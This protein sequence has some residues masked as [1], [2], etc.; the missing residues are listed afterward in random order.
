MNRRLL[1]VSL[2]ALA[3]VAIAVVAFV[4]A[5]TLA[6]SEAARVRAVVLAVRD[7]PPGS[8][9]T[10]DGR[11]SRLILVR[12][13]EDKVFAF[14]VPQEGGRVGMPDLR[15]HRPI[16]ACSDFRLSGSLESLRDTAEFG[17]H[18]RGTPAW[19]ASRW[20]WRIDGT[21]VVEGSGIENLPRVRVQR[22]ALGFEVY[23]WDF[24]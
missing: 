5:R 24:W 11:T 19:W 8:Y 18:D 4:L 12:T 23:R 16:Y 7:F 6:P 9:R 21:R 2:S 20:R 14:S 22:V 1:W 17:C 13:L 15:W 10:V 3:A